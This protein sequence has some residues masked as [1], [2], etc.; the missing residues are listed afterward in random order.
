MFR[1]N[2]RDICKYCDMDLISEKY[3]WYRSLQVEKGCRGVSGI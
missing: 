1:E 2:Y 3:A